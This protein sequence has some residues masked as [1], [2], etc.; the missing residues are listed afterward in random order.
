MQFPVQIDDSQGINDALNYL[1]SGPA[2]LG[3]NF[4]GF[5][6]YVPAYLR[7]SGLQP[8]SLPITSTL[9]SSV[10]VAMSISNITIDGGNPSS[11]ITVTFA[12]PFATVP[13]EF[14]DKIDI[15]GVIETA[16]DPDH[17]TSYNQGGLHVYSCTT[18]EVVLGND[19]AY[20]PQSWYTYV[21]GGTIGRDFMNY[22]LDTDCNAHVTV[23][24]A[25]TQ[26]FISAQLNL[27]WDYTCNVESNYDIVVTIYR[28]RGFP[29][30]TPGSKEYLF[31]D[32]QV[33]SER[34]YTRHATVGTGNDNLEAIFTT[35]LD[36]PNL[37]FG[38]YWY[39]LAVQ[40]NVPSSTPP[41]EVEIGK[42]TTGLRSLTAQVIKQ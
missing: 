33:V 18:T 14:G 23:T 40:F 24:G 16:V 3:Q 15:Y 4:E 42:V 41:Y 28:N 9:D 38:Y 35:V 25:T 11:F 20:S 10:Y 26:V 39:I 6:A 29:S 19:S 8:W 2:G 17:Q 27:I 7:P 30:D 5:S 31:G 12:T 32:A 34:T 22:E 37:Q 36:G 1:L 21:S 13:F